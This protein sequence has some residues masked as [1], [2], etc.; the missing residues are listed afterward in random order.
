MTRYVR[1]QFTDPAPGA[2]AA[3]RVRAKQRSTA[4][5]KGRS[6]VKKRVVRKA[7]YSDEEDES[8]EEEIEL[9]VKA[10]QG[11]V[12]TG[13]AVMDTE[14]DLD[15]DH[16]LILKSSLPLLKSRNSG[17]VLGVCALH[18]YC[19]SQSG[20]VSTQIGKSLVRI[21][22]NHREIQYVVLTCISTMAQERPAMFR[23]FLPDFLVKGT[24]PVFNRYICT[25][26]VAA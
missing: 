18:Y 9:E 6:T 20:T 14:G 13:G 23:A 17:V 15:P 1:N 4:A 26:L 5:V 16:R 12:F 21:L 11:S 7:F 2:A 3:A 19:G 10:E 25:C 22:R 8:D 24:D